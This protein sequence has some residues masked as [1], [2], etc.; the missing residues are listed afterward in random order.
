MLLSSKTTAVPLD[1]AVHFPPGLERKRAPQLPG[2]ALKFPAR[3]LGGLLCQLRV[4]F[5]D[6]LSQRAEGG[7]GI[8]ILF[9]QIFLLKSLQRGHRFSPPRGYD[10]LA[11]LAIADQ[12]GKLK[13]QNAPVL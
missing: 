12:K 13:K 7:S 3:L 5:Q 2:D 11:F 8:L 10:R 9:L 6:L 1:E 4:P